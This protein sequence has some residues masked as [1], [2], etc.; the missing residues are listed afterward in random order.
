MEWLEIKFSY[1]VIASSIAD[2]G[3]LVDEGVMRRPYAVDEL[4][5]V[6]ATLEFGRLMLIELELETVC[7]FD[8]L[9]TSTKHLA[10]QCKASTC[11]GF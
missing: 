2:M 6:S 11:F 1:I 10:N 5:L 8:S 9:C 4:R 7:S 3:S